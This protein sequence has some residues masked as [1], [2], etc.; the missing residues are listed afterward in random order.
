LFK[1]SAQTLDHF[2]NRVTNIALLSAG[3]LIM[4]MGWLSTYGVGRRY[5]LHNP[6]PYSYELSTIFLVACVMLAIAGVQMLGRHLR[7][8]FVAT[9][10]PQSVQ[11]VLL[12]IVIPLLA[13][14][15]VGIITWQGWNAAWYSL[16]VHETSQS[17]WRE[18]WWPTKMVVPVGAGLLCI[19]LLAQLSRGIASLIHKIRH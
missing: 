16:T 8:D 9:R 15:Y 18:P 7:V 13:L 11:A 4:I 19:I 1:R 5:L 12:D 6:E 3:M 2:I 10:Y 14:F 17:A